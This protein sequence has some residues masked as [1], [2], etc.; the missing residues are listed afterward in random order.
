LGE[1]ERRLI[2]AV[3]IERLK[4]KAVE[5]RSKTVDQ[6]CSRMLTLSGRTP[7]HQ[8]ENELEDE[9]EEEESGPLM[10]S[11]T[12]R[13]IKVLQKVDSEEAEDPF[14]S[15]SWTEDEASLASLARTQLDP[16]EPVCQFFPK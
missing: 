9:P 12:Q 16:F 11:R 4:S 7:R 5:S 14:D 3:C 10:M 6:K 8:S 15:F 13:A 2:C 1:V